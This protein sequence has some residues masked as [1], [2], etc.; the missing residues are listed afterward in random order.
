MYKNYIKFLATSV[1]I[2]GGGATLNH[3]CYCMEDTKEIT[4]YNDSV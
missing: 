3:N 2:L 4:D 1:I